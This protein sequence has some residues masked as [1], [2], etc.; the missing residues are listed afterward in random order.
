MKFDTMKKFTSKQFKQ[1]V[2]LDP[3]WASKLIEPVE[4]IDCCDM[5]ASKI[6]HLSPFLHFTG[7]DN[8]GRAAKFRGCEALKVAEGK[9]SGAVCFHSSGVEQ[10]GD[11]VVTHPNKDGFAAS[12]HECKS[13]SVARGSFAGYVKFSC[14]GIQRIDRD[15]LH[16]LQAN[17]LG[18]AANFRG[19][20]FLQVAEGDYPGFVTFEDSAIERIA[21]LNVTQPDRNGNACNFELC[22]KL[23]I[24]E[25]RYNGHVNFFDSGIEKI[26]NLVISRP[27]NK[28]NAASFGFCLQLKIAEGT[29]PGFVDFHYSTVEDFKNLIIT[30]P[31]RDDQWI[32]IR[33]TDLGLNTAKVNKLFDLIFREKTLGEIAR[34]CSKLHPDEVELRRAYE[35]RVAKCLLKTPLIE[36]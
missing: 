32:H 18:F 6:T 29:F 9:Y 5:M 27:N 7:R 31:N 36:L 20:D 25:G 28:G 23:K 1:A 19:C 26:G 14:S 24:A 22:S 8:L 30:Q 33:V 13:L 3:A 11:L 15:N 34:T 21:N 17:H 10:I 4:I 12:F 35:Y 2:D 16:I